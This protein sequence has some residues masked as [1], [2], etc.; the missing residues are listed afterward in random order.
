MVMPY[1]RQ[2]E[3]FCQDSEGSEGKHTLSPLSTSIDIC[4]PLMPPHHLHL[5]ERVELEVL[6]VSK[7]LKVLKVLKTV[8][9]LKLFKVL[10]I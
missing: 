4:V 8:N 1:W 3:G 9:V 5:K 7:V 2:D 10:K 6:K